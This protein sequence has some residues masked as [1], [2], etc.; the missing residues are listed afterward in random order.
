MGRPAALKED[1]E[2]EEEEA[3]AAAAAAAAVVG[4]AISGLGP[5]MPPTNG[6]TAAPEASVSAGAAASCER[7][8]ERKG[9]RAKTFTHQ[10]KQYTKITM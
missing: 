6:A 5:N 10:G 7:E 3:A 1:E 2:E 4:I 9:N 8:K